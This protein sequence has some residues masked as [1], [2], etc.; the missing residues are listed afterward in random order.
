MTEEPCDIAV[1]YDDG[2]SEVYRRVTGDRV[3]ELENL[4]FT[5]ANVVSTESKTS[6]A[7]PHPEFIDFH[8]ELD[9]L[10]ELVESA[11]DAQRTGQPLA[12]LG[13]AAHARDLLADR[14][15]GLVG[16]ARLGGASWE[17]IGRELGLSK[18]TAYNRFVSC[19][20]TRW[21]GTSPRCAAAGL[22]AGDTDLC[23]GDQEAVKVFESS[24]PVPEQAKAP[25]G[26]L[27]CV[28]HGA[29]LY[30]R[31]DPSRSLVYPVG[32]PNRPE[33]PAI[34]VYTRAQE[35][36]TKATKGQAA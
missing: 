26:T 14:F 24:R 6:A 23:E 33:Q 22:L 8:R 7:R 16:A 20:P 28:R 17:A 29:K 27:A 31:I 15:G 19:D 18:Q 30:A 5:A 36:R 21:D 13:L 3:R 34:E 9:Q 32:G 12:A 1:H 2:T 35:I 25:G 10:V 4:A 11:G